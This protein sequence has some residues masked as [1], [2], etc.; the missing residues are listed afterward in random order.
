[1]TIHYELK[2]SGKTSCH[3]LPQF[4]HNHGRHDNVFWPGTV[5]AIYHTVAAL[6]FGRQIRFT[7][8]CGTVTKMSDSKRSKAATDMKKG[9]RKLR[10]KTHRLLRESDEVLE[11]ARVAVERLDDLIDR[12]RDRRTLRR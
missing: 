12:V 1:M 11:R 6:V 5:F 8:S 7:A 4:R 2:G 9:D 3:F 10:E